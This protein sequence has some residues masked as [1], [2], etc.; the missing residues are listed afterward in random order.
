MTKDSRT[1][2]ELKRDNQNKKFYLNG[3]ES[4]KLDT[5]RI[6]NIK[7]VLNNLD[8]YSVAKPNIELLSPD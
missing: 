4:Q 6:D 8:F 2:W 1:L 3:Q 5:D 7:T